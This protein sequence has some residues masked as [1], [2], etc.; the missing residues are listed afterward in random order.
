MK[1]IVYFL[2]TVIC[3]AVTSCKGKVTVLTSDED[4][5]RAL[6]TPLIGTITNEGKTMGGD[7]P[8]AQVFEF[9]F[10]G[11]M[12]GLPYRLTLSR[13]AQFEDCAGCIGD[14]QKGMLSSLTYNDTGSISLREF[15][16][17]MVHSNEQLSPIGTSDMTWSTSSYKWR[18]SFTNESGV[19]RVEADGAI[20]K[21]AVFIK[22]P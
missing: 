19:Y 7:G 20:E 11:Y 17:Q 21:W 8:K 13:N 4:V 10:K 5:Y 14:W 12:T 2:C 22:T 9:S 15:I 6:Q 18:I 1:R 16:V 3:L